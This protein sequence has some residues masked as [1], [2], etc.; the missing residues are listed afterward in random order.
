MHALNA[1][2]R[3]KPSEAGGDRRRCAR[4]AMLAVVTVDI[5]RPARHRIAR[6]TNELEFPL[7][8]EPV[9][10]DGQVDVADAASLGSIGLW[11]GSIDADNGSDAHRRERVKSCVTLGS[12]ARYE[13]LVVG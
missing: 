10:T 9:V 13:S 6:G 2:R 1:I 7:L 3:T 11:L 5:H 12:A 8:V 4:A